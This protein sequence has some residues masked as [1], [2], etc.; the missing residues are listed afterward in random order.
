MYPIQNPTIVNC[1]WFVLTFIS[2]LLF[3]V[4]GVEM[5]RARHE[6]AAS[7]LKSAEDVVDLVVFYNPEG[8]LY[9]CGTSSQI[10]ISYVHEI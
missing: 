7:V 9:M 5:F 3:E 4:N 8:D 1:F 6:K 2:F 10:A